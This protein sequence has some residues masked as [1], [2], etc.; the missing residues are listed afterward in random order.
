MDAAAATDP[1]RPHWLFAPRT[2]LHAAIAAGALLLLGYVLH[3]WMDLPRTETLIWASLAI[4]MFY[5]GR[6]ALLALRALRFDID[7]LMVVGASLAAY[8]GHPE[9]GALL[10][11]LFVLSGALEDLAM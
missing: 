1:P 2:E 8:L 4:G 10:L 6:P 7:V 9:E 5:G 3:V 11:F